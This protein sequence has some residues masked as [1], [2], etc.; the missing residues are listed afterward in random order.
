[1]NFQQNSGKS[2]VSKQE[3]NYAIYGSAIYKLFNIEKV[4]RFQRA[5][6]A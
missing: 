4:E 2:N 3:S 1:M 6:Y 5:I